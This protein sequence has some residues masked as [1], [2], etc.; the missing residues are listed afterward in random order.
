[1]DNK[2]QRIPKD[3]ATLETESL[4]TMLLFLMKDMKKYKKD[5]ICSYTYGQMEEH[6]DK[7]P[8]N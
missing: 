3:L 6:T 8:Q 4:E 5:L 7:K 1:M 2:P